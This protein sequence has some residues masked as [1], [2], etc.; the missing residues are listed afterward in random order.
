MS[1]LIVDK[2]IETTEYTYSTDFQ[3]NVSAYASVTYFEI[4]FK[5]GLNVY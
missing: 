5:T 4:F 1:G 2:A 3:G